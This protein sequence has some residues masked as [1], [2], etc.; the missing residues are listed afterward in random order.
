MQLYKPC[1]AQFFSKEKAATPCAIQRDNH[2]P[3]HIVL[4]RKIIIFFTHLS[5]DPKESVDCLKLQSSFSV[6]F[7]ATNLQEYSM[8]CRVHEVL[9]HVDN[10]FMEEILA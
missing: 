10:E 3:F 4:H 5:C 8:K 7:T 9:L 2:V 6:R 1:F